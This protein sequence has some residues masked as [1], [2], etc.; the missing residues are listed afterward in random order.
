SGPSPYDLLCSALA[1]CTTMTLRLYADKNG[2][3]VARICTAASHFKDKDMD[4]F[5][6]QV[7][8]DGEI[9]EV[10]R[11]VLEGIAKR[12]P[13]HRTLEAGVRFEPIALKSLLE[14]SGI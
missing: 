14:P 11:Q 7:S 6:C 13:I 2:W 10:Q 1:A 9:N 4:T 3:P 5:S 12:C 8:V